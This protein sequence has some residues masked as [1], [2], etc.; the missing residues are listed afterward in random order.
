[1]KNAGCV[2]IIAP[3]QTALATTT[4]SSTSGVSRVSSNRKNGH[5][6]SAIA[7]APKTYTGRRPTRSDSAPDA[8]IASAS[9][10]I[11]TTTAVSA[12]PPGIPIWRA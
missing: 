1:V 4:A 8:G 9:T 5:A 6:H 3:W 7:T 2:P 12:T 11:P 10:A